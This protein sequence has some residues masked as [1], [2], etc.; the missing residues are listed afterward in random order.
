MIEYFQELIKLEF[1]IYGICKYVAISTGN[2]NK[3]GTRMCGVSSN[4]CGC[5]FVTWWQTV[6]LILFDII[7]KNMFWEIRIIST[8]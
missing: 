8:I 5:A 4:I 1:Y 2:T 6:C 3:Y 7:M